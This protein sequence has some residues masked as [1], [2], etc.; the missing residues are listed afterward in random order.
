MVD[1]PIS[2][3]LILFVNIAEHMFDIS[4]YLCYNILGE[5]I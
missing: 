5:Y 3:Y 4:F 2:S 1:S